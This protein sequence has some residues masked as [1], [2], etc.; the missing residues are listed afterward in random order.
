MSGL[1]LWLDP[2]SVDAQYAILHRYSA[3]AGSQFGGERCRF[4]VLDIDGFRHYRNMPDFC[5]G[6]EGYAPLPEEKEVTENS[7]G[8]NPAS[9]QAAAP[10]L[11]QTLPLRER[12][13]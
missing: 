1:W 8:S 5:N 2:V 11:P 6:M 12:V 4:F 9:E 3:I 7:T 10:P 13:T